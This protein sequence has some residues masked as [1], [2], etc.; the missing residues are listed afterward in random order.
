MAR[1]IKNTGSVWVLVLLLLVG[2]LSGGALGNALA[3]SLP[4]LNSTT[5]V[6]LKP[7]TLDLQFFNLTFGFTFALGPLT[8]LG[9]ILG[10]IVYRKL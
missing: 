4:W 10:Y 7:S 5:Q 8:A 6:G 3:P 2:G 1:S 9:M